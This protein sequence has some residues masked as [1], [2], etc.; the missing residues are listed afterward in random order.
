[1]QRTTFPAACVLQAL[2]T[3]DRYGFSVM[4][5]TGLAS[6]TVYQILRRF[7]RD[8]LVRS[9]WEKTG[10]AVGEGRPRRRYYELTRVGRAALARA[11]E[12]YRRQL[13]VFERPATP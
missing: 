5:T 3:G 2:A 4:D 12:R 1:M 7:E 11:A 10:E 8:G 9:S 6:G 13:A